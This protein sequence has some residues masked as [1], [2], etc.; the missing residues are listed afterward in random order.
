M[1]PSSRLCHDPVG[2]VTETGRRSSTKDKNAKDNF[3]GGFASLT[4]R[5]EKSCKMQNASQMITTDDRDDGEEEDYVF[6]RFQARKTNIFSTT[7]TI[8]IVPNQNLQQ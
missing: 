2:V 4:V 5:S 7:N 8:T 6:S 1:T 3:S